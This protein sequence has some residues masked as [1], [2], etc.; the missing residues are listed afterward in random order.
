MRTP[1]LAVLFALAACGESP[2]DSPEQPQAARTKPASGQ[3]DR[4]HK[5]EAAPEAPFEDPG[6][7]RVTLAEFAGKPLLLNLWATWCAPCV[8]EM[9]TLDALAL[10]EGKKLQVMTV[11]QD[12]EGREKV[13]AFLARHKF[14]ALEGWLDPEMALMTA[15]KANSLPMTILYDAQGREVWRVTGPVDWQGPRAAALVGEASPAAAR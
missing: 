13:E 11:S 4:S 5:G 7:E 14:K 15:L 12:L 9:P 3:V 8:E 6:G 1:F 2:A 10:R